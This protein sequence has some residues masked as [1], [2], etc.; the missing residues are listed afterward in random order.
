VPASRAVVPVIA[1]VGVVA[2]LAM[3][4]LMMA[5]PTV[6]ART[7]DESFQCLAPYDVVLNNASNDPDGDPGLPGEDISGECETVAHHRFYAGLASGAVALVL[8]LAAIVIAVR[9]R[10]GARTAAVAE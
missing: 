3:I 8:L 4:P 5:N 7:T 10:S 1:V 6:E 2:A 9:R